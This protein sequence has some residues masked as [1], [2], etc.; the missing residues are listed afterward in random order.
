MNIGKL[1]YWSLLLLI[2][3][4]GLAFSSAR[5][6]VPPKVDYSNSQMWFI[7]MNDTTGDGA[8]VFY[9]PATW[10]FDWYTPDS[11]VSHYADPSQEKHRSHM[12]IEMKK[13]N[14]IRGEGNNFYSPYYRHITLNTWATLDENY[15]DS[16]YFPVSF[17]DVENA[18]NQYLQSNPCRPII[19]A[20]FSQGAKSVV[21][22]LKRMD[23]TVYDRLVAAYVIGYKVTPSDTNTAP[24]LKGA[25]KEDDTGVVICYNSVKEK[26]YIKP[27][28]STPNVFGINPVNW[29]TDQ[30]PATLSDSITVTLDPT[31]NVLIVNG[32]DGNEYKPIL[33][34]INTGDL[35]GADPYLYQE[36]LRKNVKTRLR[37]FQK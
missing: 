27:I 21:E 6:Y 33:D 32:Y 31:T 36:S 23:S 29:R 7:S 20:G 13:L 15:I 3:G 14:N 1:W 11:V 12:A 8:D 24:W 25:A 9:I 30:T 19:L 22:L 17:L 37:S 28:I 2:A 4:A 18:F 16:L 34:F 10:E 26:H 35:H 5:E